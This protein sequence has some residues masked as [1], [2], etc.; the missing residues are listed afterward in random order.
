MIKTYRAP[1]GLAAFCAFFSM[2]AAAD[3]SLWRE[4]QPGEIA[5]RGDRWVAPQTGRTVELD[6]DGLRSLLIQAPMEGQA[7]PRASGAIL[8]LPMP[9]G[10]FA[11]FSLVEAPVMEPGLAAKFPDIR[12][13]AG[14]GLDD[15]TATVRLDVTPHGF[16][17]QVLSSGFE[18]YIDPFQRNDTQHYVVYTRADFGDARKRYQCGT[19]GA[20]PHEDHGLEGLKVA[21]PQ[22]DNPAGTSLRTYRLAIAST[23]SYTNAFGGTVADGIAGLT[24]LVSR[25]NGVYEREIALRLVLVANNDLIVYTNSNVG[26]IGTSPTGPDP[27]IQTTIDNAIGSANYDLGHAVGGSGGGGAITP[28]GNVCGASKARGFTSLNPP[29]GDVFDIDFVAHELGH[30]LGG[31]HTWNGCNGGGQWTATSAMEP[32]SG[33]TIMAYAGICPDN[34]QPNSDA[35]FHARSFTQI[36]Q[37]L[38]NGGPGNGNIVCG[39]TAATGNDPPDL[40]AP[41]NMTIP[42]RTP[43]QLTATGSD[44]NAGDV[45]TYNWEQVDTG[46]QEN[47][48]GA[49]GNNGTAPLFRSFNASTSPTRVF[50]SI[51]YILD[52]ANVPP[53]TITL[54]PAG[55]TFRPAEVLPDP[56]TGTRVMNFRVTARDNR[57]GGGGLRHSAN[58]QVT[59][60]ADVGPF[61]VGNVT[62]T[63]T[64]GGTLGITW[65]VANT[66]QAP[67]STSQVNILISLDGGN[68]F[69]TLLAG[70]ANDGAETVTLPNI[71]TSRARIKVE[72]ANGTGIA[73]GNT[74]FDISDSNFQISAGGTPVTITVSTA[75]GDIIATQ[76]GSPA[77]A[78]RNIATI[79]GGVAPFTLAADSFPPSP[80]IEIQQLQLSGNTVSAT[81]EVSCQLAAPNL[82]SFRTYPGVLRVTDSGGRQASAVFP[83]NVSN[84]SI[85]TLGT[86]AN[87]VVAPGNGLNVSPSAGPAD[88]NG[89]QTT[90]TVTPTTLPGGGTISVAPDGTVSVTTTAGTTLGTY[91]ITV[92]VGDTCGARASRTFNLAVVSPNPVMALGTRTVTS[93]NG[94]LEPREC[95][96]LDVSVS[97]SGGSAATVVSAVLSSSTPGVTITQAN[98][99]YPDIP[100]NGSQI[101]NTDY[102]VST[103]ASLTCGSTVSFTH[104]VTYAGG[105]PTVFNFDLPVGAPPAANYTFASQTGTTAPTGATLVTGSQDDDVVLPVSLPGGFAFQV[106]GTPVTQLRVDTNG[107]VIFNSGAAASTA[108][109]GALPS[110]AYGAPALFALWDDLDMRT[111]VATGGG[112]YTQSS[113]TA[114]NRTFDIQWRAVR[115]VTG[116]ATPI[117]PTMVFTVRLH[118]TSNLIEV[119]YTTVTGNGGGASGSSATVGIQAAGTG[120]VFTQFSNNQATLSAGQR[121]SVTRAAGVCQVGPNVCGELPDPVFANGFE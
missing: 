105:G 107:V 95:N 68:T 9:N 8:S 36:W 37:I 23:S 78:P 42:E 62:G 102:E 79:A 97:N 76:Q 99:T 44:P 7:A 116:A 113:G 63:Q 55:G 56:A 51:R 88:A 71:D 11:R 30:Q 38:N 77:P 114:P 89:N 69:Q 47:L 45:V 27:V 106:Y 72:A 61:L 115:F 21:N 84:N 80:D 75:S 85:P 90:V 96:T 33:S 73:A 86:Y 52:N 117:A 6:M 28:L 43:F 64:G 70:T 65:T 24:T 81:A 39:T 2:A 101:N 120:T 121:L 111:T 1:A 98:S 92:S 118:E 12:T 48:P 104:T 60:V 91:P 25:L 40:T 26:P 57:A 54:P 32:G 5:A 18:A 34:I 49:G 82:P 59:A 66:D 41:A 14:Q 50:P 35:Y 100:S 67:V 87:Q 20:D 19:D 103:A 109:N 112:I 93:G 94:I 22:P 83:I 108:A 110:G 13:Y 29:R 3:E 58:V 15:G 4:V 74:Y 16:H 31:S 46:T 10:G 119:Y 53:A 17:A